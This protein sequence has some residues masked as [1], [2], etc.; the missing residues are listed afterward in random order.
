MIK[1]NKTLTT[2]YSESF[3]LTFSC[4]NY[5]FFLLEKDVQTQTEYAHRLLLWLDQISSLFN[6]FIL[7]LSS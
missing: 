4:D 2:F 1:I 6:Y 5:P 3:T 7:F